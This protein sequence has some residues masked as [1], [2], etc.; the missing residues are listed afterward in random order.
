MAG[1]ET[2]RARRH[3]HRDFAI[4]MLVV[5]NGAVELE[6]RVGSEREVGAVGHHQP[7]C[8]VDPGAHG[9]VTDQSIADL[10]LGGRRSG[11]AE[12]FIL[13]DGRFADTRLRIAREQPTQLPGQQL[14]SQLQIAN[15]SSY[16]NSFSKPIDLSRHRTGSRAHA[17]W[18]N[19]HS[20]GLLARRLV[21][22]ESKC[23]Q[24]DGHKNPE[25]S[26]SILPQCHFVPDSVPDCP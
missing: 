9:F 20:R 15:Q 17:M 26:H 18:Q 14:P 24:C 21:I 22:A 7:R 6:R 12:H 4:V 11:N 25:P 23:V 3:A 2:K 10:D 5:E 8:A 1:D 13:D 19:Y 16:R